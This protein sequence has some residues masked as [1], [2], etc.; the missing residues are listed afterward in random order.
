MTTPIKLVTAPTM[1]DTVKSEV[2]SFLERT[3]EQ[4]KNGE[5]NSVIIIGCHDDSGKWFTYVTD[6][7][8][9]SRAIGQMAILTSDMIASAREN[10]DA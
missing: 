9:M 2:V 10:S 1:A 8:D 5:I 4:A 3:L 6:Q 7:L